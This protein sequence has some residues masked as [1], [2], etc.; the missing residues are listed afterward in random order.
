M[1]LYRY[2]IQKNKHRE[3]SHNLQETTWM[4]DLSHHCLCRAAL[5]FASS[6]IYA[7]TSHTAVPA[8]P[9]G[10]HA[11]RL[12]TSRASQLIPGI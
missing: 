7:R 12:M 1:R 5:I 3:R 8:V 9:P 10:D 4:Q 2:L 11:G 6:Y